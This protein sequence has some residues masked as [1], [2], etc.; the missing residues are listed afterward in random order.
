MFLRQPDPPT[1]KVTG[2]CGHLVWV[3]SVLV[4]SCI[5]LLR[6]G[7]GAFSKKAGLGHGLKR[8]LC[9]WAGLRAFTTRWSLII[10]MSGGCVGVLPLLI[11]G[12]GGVWYLDQAYS[13]GLL[14]QVFYLFREVVPK[15]QVGGCVLLVLH[16]PAI[17]DCVQA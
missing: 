10:T 15:Q 16:N 7:V 11:M 9:R 4:S 1:S 3:V 2:F 17:L 14:I 8:P 5:V 12:F 6:C 13:L